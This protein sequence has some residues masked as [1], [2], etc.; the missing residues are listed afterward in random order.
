MTSNPTPRHPSKRKHVHT[1]SCKQVFKAELFLIARM[2][3]QLKGQ[4]T[5]EWINKMP[6]MHYSFAINTRIDTSHNMHEPWKHTA[7][8]QPDTWGY[9]L[10]DS[11]NE[12]FRISSSTEWPSGKRAWQVCCNRLLITVISQNWRL[13]VQNLGHALCK[14]RTRKTLSHVFPISVSPGYSWHCL[15]CGCITPAPVADLT[16]P[17]PSCDRP[18][19]VTTH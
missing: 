2:L 14:A 1:E 19:L 16:W 10:C 12:M 11:F 6:Y 15:A 3:K 4:S 8:K 18:P 17:S 7:L 9:M 13:E 5:Y